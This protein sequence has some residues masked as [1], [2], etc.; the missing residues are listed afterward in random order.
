MCRPSRK[1]DWV[2][3]LF[4][5]FVFKTTK[6]VNWHWLVA[7]DGNPSQKT[8]SLCFSHHR[9]KPAAL[10]STRPL[11]SMLPS[12]YSLYPFLSIPHNP[13]QPVYFLSIRSYYNE[14]GFFKQLSSVHSSA[15]HWFTYLACMALILLILL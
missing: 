1:G 3:F 10:D 6:Y 15:G 5:H 4:S 7:N 2:N 13:F 9:H 14:I 8:V 12:A 11:L